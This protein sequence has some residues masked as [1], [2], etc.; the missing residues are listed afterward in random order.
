M[1]SVLADTFRAALTRLTNDEQKLVKQTVYDLQDD[2]T[3]PGLSM[4]RMDKT[5]SAD[6]WSVRVGRDIRII[7]QRSGADLILAYVAHHDDA[8][9]WAERRRIEAHPTTGALQV[10]EVRELVE[11]VAA[12]VPAAEQSPVAEPA[13][14]AG[15]SEED[16]LSVGVPVDWIADVQ[17]VTEDG[18][19]DLAEHLPEE[20]REALLEYATTG[21]LTRAAPPAD[22]PLEHPDTQRRFRIMEGIEEIKAALDAPFEKWAVFLHPSQRTTVERAF[23]GPARVMGSAGTGK[24]V[25][26]LHRVQRILQSDPDARVLLTTFSDPL[27]RALETKLRVLVGDRPALLERVTVVS[28]DRVAAQL[29][30]LATGQKPSMAPAQFIRTQLRKAADEADV[31]EVSS[32]FLHSEW[33]NVIDPWQLDSLQAYAEVPRVG[34]K[35]RLG[36]R[37]RERLWRVFAAVRNHLAARRAFTP[38]SLFAETAALYRDKDPK[39]F[40]H[41]V[42]DE[43]QD[44][45]VAELRFLSAIAADRPDALFFAGDLGQ[46][47]FR[48]PFSWKGLGVDVRGRSV[49]LKVNYRTSHQIRRAADRLLPRSVRDLDGISDDRAGTI[50]VFDGP[51]PEVHVCASQ[52]EERNRAAQVL[53]DAL[54]AGFTPSEIGVFVRSEAQLARARAAVRAA[55]MQARSLVERAREEENTV[56]V[57]TM[58]LAK[59]LE[60]PMVLLMACEQD[61]LPLEERI[62]QVAD[63]FELDEVLTTERQML[64]VAVTRARDRLVITATSPASEFID[65]LLGTGSKVVALRGAQTPSSIS[66]LM[67]FR[68]LCAFLRSGVPAVRSTYCPRWVPRIE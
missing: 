31:T 54:G 65:D 23:S 9:A 11:Q 7:L 56:L 68:S 14:F 40:T 5:R 51:E 13:L 66:V 33:D 61:V 60:F 45:G 49:T 55:G 42:V 24:T 53:T 12:P 26:A 35:N 41:I 32:Q 48:Q 59:G 29:Y 19:F 22:N 16:L 38:S 37:Q 20:A 50:S 67:R 21:R 39:P 4:H 30:T 25:V 44:L 28:F 6:I 36:P 2:P 3:Q 17:A 46:R 15:L 62:E 63:E 57:G 52:D 10:V 1:P 47:I 64:Y 8:Y 43:A 18:F 58:H 34:R 27:S